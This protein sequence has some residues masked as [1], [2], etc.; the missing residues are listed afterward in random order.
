MSNGTG[1]GTV[2]VEDI[3][4]GGSSTPKSL[5]AV[6]ALLFFSADDGTHDRELWK[7]DGI[8]DGTEMLPEFNPAGG[9]RFEEITDAK[10]IGFFMCDDGSSGE[11]LCTSNASG[12]ESGLID[13]LNLDGDSSPSDFL[14]VGDLLFHVSSGEFG[15]DRELWTYFVP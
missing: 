14:Y 2:E 15:D 1:P 6:G 12:D 9:S 3:N 4:P 7:S 8:A 10:G 13:N 11:E 5:A